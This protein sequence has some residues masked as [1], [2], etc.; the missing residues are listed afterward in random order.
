[1]LGLALVVC[2]T[3]KATDGFVKLGRNGVIVSP[4]QYSDPDTGRLQPERVSALLATGC[5]LILNEVEKMVP[6]ARELCNDVIAVTGTKAHINAYLTP[7]HA[8]GFPVHFD[9]HD[10]L[11]V[12]LA[13]CKRWRIYPGGVA[14]ATPSVKHLNTYSTEETPLDE[15]SLAPNDVAYV[16]RGV[17]HQ[18]TTDI[19]P[20][21]H[22][23]VGLDPRTK[24]DALRDLVTNAER[25][26]EWI[27]ESVS[28]G[29]G[30]GEE[31]IRR[32]VATPRRPDSV[33]RAAPM[34]RLKMFEAGSWLEVKP[35]T[36]IRAV[37]EAALDGEGRDVRL[38]FSGRTLLFPEQVARHLELI[39]SGADVTVED[40]PATI[41]LRGRLTL[42]RR[43]VSEG[44]ASVVEHGEA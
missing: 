22:F 31:D 17:M 13:G 25:H 39:C 15:F 23:T 32:L 40:L 24:A 11:V 10:V 37:A 27:R 16:P 1:M 29:G 7:A 34:P 14:Q 42:V 5:S 8:Q 4:A 12:Q 43:L 33:E 44:A 20:S 36:K 38:R 21:L 18:A 6:I 26:H 9:A 28:E 30:L 41:D 2:A 19:S 35:T 3:S